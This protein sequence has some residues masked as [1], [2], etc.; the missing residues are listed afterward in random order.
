MSNQFFFFRAGKSLTRI[1]LEEILYLE[2]DDN[3]VWFFA[4]TYKCMVRTSLDAA[5]R[6][7]PENQF[8]QINRSFAVALVHLESISREMV[9]VASAEL[10]VSKKYY[11]GLM[12]KI[13]VIE[14]AVG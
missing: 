7:L 5:L 6:Q 1:R 8:A 14:A 3:Y 12:A 2:A 10:P 13:K 9:R 11:P 4:L